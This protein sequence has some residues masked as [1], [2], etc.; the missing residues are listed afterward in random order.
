MPQLRLPLYNK[1]PVHQMLISHMG[2]GVYLGKM[3]I[4]I[5][6]KLFKII[7]LIDKRDLQVLLDRFLLTLKTLNQAKINKCH[8]LLKIDKCPNQPK[9]IK[10]M[11]KRISKVQTVSHNNKAIQAQVFSQDLVLRAL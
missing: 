1:H 7:T 2:L 6:N 3:R 9:I 4:I 10:L 5:V 8:N 11:N